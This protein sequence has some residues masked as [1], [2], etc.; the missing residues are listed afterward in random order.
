MRQQP[1]PKINSGCLLISSALASLVFWSLIINAG[2]RDW[3][4]IVGTVI[5]I[6]KVKLSR[7]L[8]VSFTGLMLALSSCNKETENQEDYDFLPDVYVAGYEKN[9][10]GINVA[11]IWK[12]GVAQNLSNGTTDASAFS[13]FVFGNDVYAC[14]YEKNSLGFYNA[15]LWKN[16]VVKTLHNTDFTS[17]ANAVFVSGNNV[18]VCF[19]IINS[20]C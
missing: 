9:A 19:C 12:N 4:I 6:R 20:G 14:G 13:V 3:A 5:F 11:K 15:M 8:A 2:N 1:K 18:A 17:Y 10:N 7:L 16:G